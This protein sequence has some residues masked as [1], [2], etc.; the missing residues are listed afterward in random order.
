MDVLQALLDRHNAD[1]EIKEPG[2]TPC[3]FV[4]FRS[5]SMLTILSPAD[6]TE[7]KAALDWRGNWLK[8][9]RHYSIGRPTA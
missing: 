2:D 8:S 4:P 6:V 7:I 3:D 1:G 5:C 9:K